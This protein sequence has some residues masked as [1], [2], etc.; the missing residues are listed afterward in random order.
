MPFIKPQLAHKMPENL[1]E[2]RPEVGEWAVEEKYDGERFCVEIGNGPPESLFA[3]RPVG[4]WS[5]YGRSRELPTHIHAFLR[6]IHVNVI[7]DGELT[8]PGGRSYGVKELTNQKKLVFVVFDI[9]EVNGE[10]T[11][12]LTYDERRTLLEQLLRDRCLD[13]NH[14]GDEYGEYDNRGCGNANCFNHKKNGFVRVQAV[15]IAWSCPVDTVE[16]IKQLRD[17]VYARDGEGLIVKRRRGKYRPG[18]RSKDFL[19]IKQLRSATLTL[20][21]FSPGRGKIVNRGPHAVMIGRDD[22]GNVTTVKTLDDKM[23][24]YLDRRVMTGHPHPDIGRRF[25]IEYQERTPDMSYR[26]GRF[27][28]WE[29]E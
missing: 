27:D 24:A 3:G 22:D 25:L 11:T 5:R 21:G 26:H 17:E 20:I 28:R 16:R 29:N 2:W 8:V 14:N 12:D 4:A 6:S 15:Q 23:L 7:L 18:K 13:P 1:I 9:L 19:K 10:T